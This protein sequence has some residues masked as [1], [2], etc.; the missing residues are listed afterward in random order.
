MFWSI[1]YGKAGL[2]HG[3]AVAGDGPSIAFNAQAVTVA[4]QIAAA[5]PS[6]R[7]AGGPA[8]RV[9]TWAGAGRGP[10]RESQWDRK[11]E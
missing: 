5:E 11:L 6:G 10:G 7:S 9:I 1:C 2:A 8:G 3:R 4:A